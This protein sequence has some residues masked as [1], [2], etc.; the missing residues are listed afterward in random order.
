VK[1][2]DDTTD[3]VI[4]K[5][6]AFGAKDLDGV[7]QSYLWYYYTDVDNSP[8]D[9]RATRTPNTSFVL[10]KITGNYYFVAVMKDNNEA[11]VSSEEITGSKY[12]I[13][14]AGDNINTPLVGLHASDTS[15]NIG[16]EVSFTAKVENIL[17]Q[18]IS[19]K[20]KYSWDL[21]GDGFYEKKT[22]TPEITTTFKKSG[23]IFAK[24][25]V[26]HNGFSATKSITMNVASV[27]KPEFEYV[28]IGNKFVFINNSIGTYDKIEWKLGDGTVVTNAEK[29]IHKYKDGKST[30]T[31]DVILT[32]G[33]KVKK[34]S[35]KVRNNVKNVLQARK[36]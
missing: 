7:I 34:I 1:V 11:R 6:S 13:T 21:D 22:T 35:K 12:F 17:G 27:L 33:T 30:H 31:V 8:Q 32:E 25:K 28:S 2:V 18:N 36:S 15:I 29:F 26:Q 9:F 3:P 16:E 24:V 20:S 23:E 19:K 10:P 5:V 14:L 4:V